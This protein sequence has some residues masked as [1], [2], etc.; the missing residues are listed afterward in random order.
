MR[1]PGAVEVLLPH[2]PKSVSKPEGES[3]SEEEK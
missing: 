2:S 1:I 3:W